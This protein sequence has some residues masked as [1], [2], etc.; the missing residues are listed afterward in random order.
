VALSPFS[1]LGPMGRTVDDAH[2]LLRAQLDIDRRDVYSSRDACAIPAELEAVDL[3]TVRVA[4]S[5]DLGCAPIDKDIAATFWAKVEKFRGVFASACNRDPEMTG[6]HQ[7]FEVLRGIG[8][9]AAFRDHVAHRRELLGPN[10]IDNTERALS[11]S[12][13]DVASGHLAQT[14]IY[15][16]FIDLFKDIDALI[17]PAAAVS[18]FPHRERYVTHINDEEMPTYMRWLTITYALTMALPAVCC[19]P[20]G[21][22]RRGLPFGVQI[23]GPRGS[24][25]RVLAIAKSLQQ[26][27]AGNAETERPRPDVSRL[28]A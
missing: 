20:C 27:L 16:R 21:R 17:C 7:A 18:P 3:S 2:L 28:T 24:D 13:A 5:S 11:W 23:A 9:V 25:A 8:F 4:F 14:A 12:L 15:R 1:V 22:D 10:V 6:V 26:E 19:I